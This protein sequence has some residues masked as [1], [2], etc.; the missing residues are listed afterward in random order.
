MHFY[1]QKEHSCESKMSTGKG[2][3]SLET[4]HL[5]CVN[6]C[7]LKNSLVTESFK[8]FLPLITQYWLRPKEAFFPE[9]LN[10][11][12]VKQWPSWLLAPLERFSKCD[13]E[14]R[15]Q[16]VSEQIH[17]FEGK[18]KRTSFSCCLP[19]QI[20]NNGSSWF[21]RD[22]FSIEVDTMKCFCFLSL[23]FKKEIK[24]RLQVSFIL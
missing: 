22:I 2:Y 16:R 18:N 11:H 4:C 3:I 14:L 12:F 7:L 1:F 9:L 17:F 21:P 23:L 5:R 15:A 10:W 24:I 8:T 13:F 19:W 20:P 6:I